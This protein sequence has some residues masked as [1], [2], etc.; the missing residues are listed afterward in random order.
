MIGSRSR[1]G[2]WS[3]DRGANDLDG[4]DQSTGFNLDGTRWPWSR[5][6]A[7]VFLGIDEEGEAEKLDNTAESPAALC[8]SA[9]V[10][11]IFGIFVCRLYVYGYRKF[12]SNV[13]KTVSEFR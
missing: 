5:V 3:V 7:D 4:T 8:V 1:V 13:Q 2:S 6:A 10:G 9:N 12:E 11:R